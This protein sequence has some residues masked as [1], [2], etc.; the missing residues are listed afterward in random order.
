MALLAIP[1][2][3]G[4]APVMR[5]AVAADHSLIA[6][7]VRA[8]LTGRGYEVVVIRWPQPRPARAGP[9]RRR[10]RRRAVG[11]PPHVG[12]L[13]SDLNS[14]DLLN[15]ALA[16]VEG[17]NV[18]WLVMTSAPSGPVWGAL[19]ERG[20]NLVA[21]PRIRLDLTC[22]LLEDIVRDRTT[23]PGKRRRRE[24][25]ATWRSFRRQRDD[26][27]ARLAL[28]TERE[29]TVLGRLH[30]GMTVRE[31]A[32]ADQVTESTVRSQVKAILRKLDVS[33]QIAAVAVYDSVRSGSVQP[34]S[35][36]SGPHSS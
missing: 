35:T 8:A 31:I 4:T 29:Q 16:L 17:L 12:L 34:H 5:I 23:R 28:L 21:S 14:Y 6:E 32:E 7:A 33:S 13:L 36:S 1:P 24:L 19:Y 10:Q 2:G 11:P 30:S 20:V 25:I 9:G 15:S 26:W 22:D 27:V 18:P 3:A